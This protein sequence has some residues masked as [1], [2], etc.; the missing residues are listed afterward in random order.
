PKIIASFCFFRLL[1]FGL[2][3]CTFLK[4]SASGWLLLKLPLF[5]SRMRGLTQHPFL[6]QKVLLWLAFLFC[7]IALALL[8]PQERGGKCAKSGWDKNHD[9]KHLRVG[10]RN[11]RSGK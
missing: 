7:G 6:W 11:V 1:L 3:G 10:K 5:G 2:L 8:P 4:T 9:T